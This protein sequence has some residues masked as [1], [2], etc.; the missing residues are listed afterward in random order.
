VLIGFVDNKKL[1]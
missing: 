1:M